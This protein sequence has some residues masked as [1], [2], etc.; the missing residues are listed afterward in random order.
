MATM[1]LQYVHSFVDK[2]GRVRYYFRY[3]GKRWPLPGLP[4]S[5][6]FSAAY[7][8]ARREHISSRRESNVAADHDLEAGLAR[9]V[10]M[11]PRRDRISRGVASQVMGSVACRADL[12]SRRGNHVAQAAG[13]VAAAIAVSQ[14]K[15][16]LPQRVIENSLQLLVASNP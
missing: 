11:Q 7:D 8:E 2:T 16:G 1:R 14:D 4:G 12:C 5:A 3:R 13:R 10:A 9:A 15:I 6:E